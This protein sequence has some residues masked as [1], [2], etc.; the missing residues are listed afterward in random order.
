LTE[1]KQV[2]RF[3]VDWCVGNVR[4]AFT[5]GPPD[6]KQNR[7]NPL[8]ITSYETLP[9]GTVGTEFPRQPLEA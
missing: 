9:D 7:P 2:L 1:G 6:Y 8:A 3:D 4:G 5:S